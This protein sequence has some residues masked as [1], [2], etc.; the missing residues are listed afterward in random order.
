MASKRL[1]YDF[2]SVGCGISWHLHPR[3]AARSIPMIGIN[4]S[5]LSRHTILL[6]LVLM[7]APFAARSDTFEDSAKD[8][9]RKI[10]A[11][12]PVQE[13]VILNVRNLSTL[14]PNDFAV[15][16][17]NLKSELQALGIRFA[18]TPGQTT[19]LTVTLSENMTSF[20]WAAEIRQGDSSRAVLLAFPRPAENSAGSREMP[21]AL[22]SEKFWEGSQRVLD[23]AI[24]AGSNGAHLLLLLTPDAL[25]I[26]S[27]GSDQIVAVPFSPVAMVTRDPT[28]GLTQ[29][30]NI[31]TATTASRI[32]NIDTLSRTLVDCHP[33]PVDPPTTGGVFENLLDLAQ[34]GDMHVDKGAQVA[35]APDACGIGR[36]FLAAGSGDYTEPDTILLYESTGTQG[37]IA[38][39]PLSDVLRFP[40]PV[41]SIQSGA[42][43]PRA[44]VHNLRTGNYEAY[45][46][47]ISCAQ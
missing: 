12:L 10:A 33:M 42:A 15:A 34:S 6:L 31:V 27:V 1:C 2:H 44:I 28:G 43:P 11:S 4:R 26:R 32:C 17:Q 21:F 18:G 23:A 7:G 20:V 25:L 19:S 46:I 22:H 5:T 38:E 14:R 37:V 47:S 16:E 41:L 35:S 36:Q 45:Q 39:K 8:L 9:A 24:V 3:M 40:G 30:E 13:E 29:S